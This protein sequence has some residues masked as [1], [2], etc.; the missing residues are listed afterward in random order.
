MSYFLSLNLLIRIRIIEPASWDLGTLGAFEHETCS[1]GPLWCCSGSPSFPQHSVGLRMCVSYLVG[2]ATTLAPPWREL[3]RKSTTKGA[4]GHELVSQTLPT[5][6]HAGHPRGR[7]PV[8]PLRRECRTDQAALPRAGEAGVTR[9]PV[10][11]WGRVTNVPLPRLHL[12]PQCSVVV[13]GWRPRVRQT[14]FES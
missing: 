14:G 4:A 12:G 1:A 2:K 10:R 13:K 11:P 8:S 7:A 6:P 3:I 9:A 5:A